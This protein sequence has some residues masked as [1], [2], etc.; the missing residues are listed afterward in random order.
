MAAQCWCG[1]WVW[2]RP[3]CMLTPQCCKLLGTGHQYHGD[4]VRAAQT[5][6]GHDAAR[7]LEALGTRI[8]RLERVLNGETPRIAVA[9][10]ADAAGGAASADSGLKPG[11]LT[12]P[13][14]GVNAA[15][16]GVQCIGAILPRHAPGVQCRDVATQVETILF[17]PPLPALPADAEAGDAMLHGSSLADAVASAGGHAESAMLGV[18]AETRDCQAGVPAPGTDDRRPQGCNGAADRPRPD[19][20]EPLFLC[21]GDAQRV[22]ATSAL[23]F[24]VGALVELRGLTVRKALN[25]TQ[26]LIVT[27][28]KGSPARYGVRVAGLDEAVAVQQQHMFAVTPAVLE[29]LVPRPRGAQSWAASAKHELSCMPALGRRLSGDV[30]THV[31]FAAPG[32]TVPGS[33]PGAQSESTGTCLPP[34]PVVTALCGTCEAP[35]GTRSQQIGPDCIA[36]F[37]SARADMAPSA[38]DAMSSSPMECSQMASVACKLRPPP[39]GVGPADAHMVDTSCGHDGHASVNGTSAGGTDYAKWRRFAQEASPAACTRVHA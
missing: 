39:P 4:A 30:V 33:P 37:E 11:G 15:P 26:G 19:S 6:A 12:Q 9:G 36:D 32:D 2:P 24:R 5:M 1:S 25:G 7:A 27:A 18:A 23:R 3:C 20:S 35:L 14:T 16:D 29:A 34:G 21:C 8:D 17:A 28:A 22:D 10:T 38:R 13:V 31:P